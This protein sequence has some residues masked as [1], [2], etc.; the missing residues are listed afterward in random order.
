MNQTSMKK[1]LAILF[2]AVLLAVA[3]QAR[4]EP[5]ATIVEFTSTNLQSNPLHDPALRRVLICAPSQLT[6]NAPAPIV[7]YLPGFGGSAEKSIE[8]KGKWLAFTEK[9]A[10]EVMPMRVAIVD[11]HNHWGG[12][13]Y[14]NSSAQGNYAD[15]IC[16]EV[17]AQVERRYS[18]PRTGV[19]RIIAGH[20]SG[21]YGALRLGIYKPHMFDGVVALSPDSYFQVTHLPLVQIASVSNAPLAEVRELMRAGSAKP[22]PKDGDY[23]Y[24]LALCAAYAPVGPSH[25]GDFEWLYDEHHKWRPEVW[26]R[27]MDADPLIIVQKNKNAFLPTQSIY[28][29][30]AAQD[31]F[32]ANIGAHAIYDTIKD[33]PARSTFREPPGKHSDHTMDRLQ[34]GVTWVLER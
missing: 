10:K 6:S 33:R 22:L 32:K 14:I 31:Q 23:G 19:R 13:Q 3:S 26:Q 30:G 8:N 4:T 28:L 24:A 1:T 20:S 11:G 12:S 21:G 17:V 27:W 15:Y 2:T 29:E 5:T 9:L 16:D 18:V 25:P 34:A 7:Y